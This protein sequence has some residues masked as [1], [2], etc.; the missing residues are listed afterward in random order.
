MHFSRYVLPISFLVGVGLIMG[1][2]DKATGMRN[3]K[4]GTGSKDQKEP[5]HKKGK[6]PGMPV[7]PPDPAAPPK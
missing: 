7:D 2:G 6:N 3:M 4:P 1:C 5:P